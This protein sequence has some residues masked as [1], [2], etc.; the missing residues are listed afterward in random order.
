MQ[1]G[2]SEIRLIGS[3]P[4]P[5]YCLVQVNT[6]FKKF[7]L[8]WGHFSGR[9]TMRQTRHF[10]Y[11]ELMFEKKLFKNATK[12]EFLVIQKFFPDPP[13]ELSRTKVFMGSK[14]TP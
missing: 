14:I 5:Q 1:L 11:S 4:P 3:L 10:I 12:I 6:P 2:D 7:R 8:G 13:R 9:K